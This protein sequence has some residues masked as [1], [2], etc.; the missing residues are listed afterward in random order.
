[1]DSRLVPNYMKASE[2]S[3][4]HE[5]CI[6]KRPNVQPATD[7]NHSQGDYVACDQVSQDTIWKQAVEKEKLGLK[8]WETNWGFIAEFDQRG[9][10]REKPELP[11]VEQTSIFSESVPNTNSANYGSRLNTEIGTKIQNLEYQFYSERRRR[12]LGDDMVCY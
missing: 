2:P 8:N 1:M 4:Y 10:I 11:S 3:A 9:E 5:T 12:R 6:P 7:T